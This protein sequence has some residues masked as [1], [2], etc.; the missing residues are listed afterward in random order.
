ME[1][2]DTSSKEPR[3]VFDAFFIINNKAIP[4]IEIR[5]ERPN[6]TKED[7]FGVL[8]AEAGKISNIIEDA[9]NEGE[10]TVHL[11]DLEIPINIAS[12]NIVKYSSAVIKESFLNHELKPGDIIVNRSYN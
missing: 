6:L 1:T 4:K 5:V 2:K 8:E 12:Q 10:T 7:I 3:I 9:I 11:Y